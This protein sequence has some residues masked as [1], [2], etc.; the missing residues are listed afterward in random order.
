MAVIATG[1]ARELTTAFGQ[2]LDGELRHSVLGDEYF[3][4]GH[5]R[6]WDAIARGGWL[7][8]AVTQDEGGAGLEVKDLAVVAEAWGRR[9]VPLP[10]TCT[11]M[12]RAIPAVRDRTTGADR[13]TLSVPGTG[14][15][16]LV[17]MCDDE[18]IRHLSWGPG[19]EPELDAVPPG[20]QTDLFAPSLPI[21]VGRVLRTGPDDPAVLASVATLWAAEAVGAA[22]AAFD[23]A[24][25]YAGFRQAFGRRIAEF[26]AVKH[27]IADMYKC[28]ELARTAVLWAANTPGASQRGVRLAL[29]LSKEVIEGA[30]Q[31][32]GGI[33]FTWDA[34]IHFY[35]R[36]VLA[37]DRLSQSAGQAPD[38]AGGS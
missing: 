2:L 23:A 12:L 15:A 9:I 21:G 32:E 3:S 13:L 33:G 11:M 18:K 27:R 22:G 26:Q 19:A 34:G 31:I 38:Q 30:I 20:L 14:G 29:D 35:L 7:D 1:Q 5:D 25:G 16:R 17:P 4:A 37:L 28:L 10:F 6:L 8:L 36:H 24:F